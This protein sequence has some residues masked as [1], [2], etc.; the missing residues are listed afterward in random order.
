MATSHED[1]DKALMQ[2]VVDAA[3]ALPIAQE[4][5]AFNKPTDGSPWA[6]VW[7]IPSPDGV[8]AV[9]LGDDG[10]DEHVGIVQLDLNYPTGRG[11]DDVRAKGDQVAA[12]FSVGK[13]L[14]SGVAKVTVS[15]CSR[16]RGR[17]VEGW[18]RVSMTISW[19][20]RVPRHT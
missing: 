16:S 4:N 10:E 8:R 19:Y 1:I 2:G 17:E 11:V 6:S 18:Y 3:L 14:S 12:F 20:A 7:I 9:T 15:S 13:A 5:V